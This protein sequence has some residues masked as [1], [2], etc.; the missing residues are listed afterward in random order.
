M[1]IQTPAY[2]PRCNMSSSLPTPRAAMGVRGVEI[3]L[4]HH[5]LVLVLRA[6]LSSYFTDVI[7]DRVVKTKK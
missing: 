1:H 3:I 7:L 5:W 6:N 4:R 2:E